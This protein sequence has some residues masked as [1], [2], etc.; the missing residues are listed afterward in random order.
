M[1]AV[2]QVLNHAFCLRNFNLDPLLS[3]AHICLNNAALCPNAHVV[4]WKPSQVL[5]HP[6]R[7]NSGMAAHL[8]L[9]FWDPEAELEVAFGI[10]WGREYESALYWKRESVDSY[11]SLSQEEFGKK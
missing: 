5:E 10:L 9:M 1:A 3:F 8:H 7:A 11:F 4:F 6:H 2:E